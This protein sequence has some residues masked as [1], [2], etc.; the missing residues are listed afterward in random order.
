MSLEKEQ[1]TANKIRFTKSAALTYLAITSVFVTYPYATKLAA[2]LSES[3]APFIGVAGSL[4]IYW[5]IDG[6]LSNALR[7]L[8]RGKGS[9]KKFKWRRALMVCLAT[10]TLVITG[11][12]S[13]IANFLISDAVIPQKDEKELT[14]Q[15]ITNDNLFTNTVSIFDKDIKEAKRAIYLAKTTGKKKVETAR[16]AGSLKWAREF[17]AHMDYA[18]RKIT[19]K[20][21]KRGKFF[22]WYNGVI[23]ARSDSA[24]AV[25][26]AENALALLR[27]SKTKYLASKTESEGAITT[28]FVKAQNRSDAVYTKFA[29]FLIFTD[30]T[31]G[32]VVLFCAVWLFFYF[33]DGGILPET[34]NSFLQAWDSWITEKTDKFTAWLFGTASKTVPTDRTPPHVAPVHAGSSDGFYLSRLTS[35]VEQLGERITLIEQNGKPSTDVYPSEK[36]SE[37][38]LKRRR[39]NVGKKTSRKCLSCGTDISHKRKDA[40]FCSDACRKDYHERNKG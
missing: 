24:R 34:K 35:M 23:Q 18:N 31:A 27:G 40:K 36:A 9:G 19:N 10:T 20:T 38:T 28:G 12:M 26:D 22:D 30:I 6:P 11:G 29:H 7:Y 37:K 25:Q 8:E 5:F 3:L 13:F 21:L 14:A 15:L 4:L 17:K 2:Q 16:H 33:S 1:R 39:K 32:V